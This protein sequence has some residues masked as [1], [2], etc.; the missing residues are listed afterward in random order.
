MRVVLNGY[1][2]RVLEIRRKTCVRL[3]TQ[4]GYFN[5]SK[6]P[7]QFLRKRHLWRAIAAE[8]YVFG[9]IYFLTSLRDLLYSS[10]TNIK[11]NRA[12]V[13]YAS[14]LNRLACDRRLPPG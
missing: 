13:T 10:G 2:S 8:S 5:S 4:H 12:P 6:L 14:Y 11:I 1:P 9:R 7:A 3:K